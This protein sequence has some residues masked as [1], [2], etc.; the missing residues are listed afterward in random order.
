MLPNAKKLRK[1]LSAII[2]F[3]KFREEKMAILTG[4]MFKLLD[5][6]TLDVCTDDICTTEQTKQRQSLLDGLAKAKASNEKLVKSLSTLKEQTAEEASVIASLE[7]E[8]NAMEASIAQLNNEQA[9]IRE[10][11]T[12]LKSVSNELRNA[13]SAEALKLEELR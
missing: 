4:K 2:N 1:Q 8:C 10:E 12:E 5:C 3:I 7:K 6:F 11:S 9:E 13:I